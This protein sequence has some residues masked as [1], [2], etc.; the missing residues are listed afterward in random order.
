M[1]SWDEFL[2]WSSQY[3]WLP[4]IMHGTFVRGA[5]E[6]AFPLAVRSAA[7]LWHLSVGQPC[8][9]QQY[10]SDYIRKVPPTD[11]AGL[12]TIVENH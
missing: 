10:G 1:V 4:R 8:C 12:S 3:R 11:S 7:V 5:L 6:Y 9:S 2:P